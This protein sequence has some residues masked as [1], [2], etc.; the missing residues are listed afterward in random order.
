MFMDLGW[1]LIDG[2]VAPFVMWL[3]LFGEDFGF[4]D[5]TRGGFWYKFGFIT[6]IGGLGSTVFQARR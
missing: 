1:G 4:Y 2:F 5:A 6:G 3:N